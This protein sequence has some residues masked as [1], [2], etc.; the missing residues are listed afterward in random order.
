ME[1]LE[2]K[3]T[4]EEIEENKTPIDPKD[5]QAIAKAAAEALDNKKGKD[6]KIVPVQDKT[7]IAEFFVL[8]T[9]NSTTHVKSLRGEVEF[10]LEERGVKTLHVEGRDSNSWLILDYAGVVV[11]IFSREA[12]EYYNL[13]KLYDAQ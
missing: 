10:R 9:A 5:Y 2:L 6:V 11:H 8:A 7:D 1:E 12:R 13:D 3:Q 4:Q